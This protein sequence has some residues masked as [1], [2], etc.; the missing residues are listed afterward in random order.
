MH[1]LS[2]SDDG[3]VAYMAH[4]G[5]GFFML[6]SSQIAN[7][8]SPYPAGSPT[9][10]LPAITPLM[11]RVDISPPYYPAVHSALK[12]PGRSV[13]IF[14][15]E[16]YPVDYGMEGCPWGWGW[17]VD[18]SNPAMPH[19]FQTTDPNT[20]AVTTYGQMRLPFN[21]Q[22][23]CPSADQ[24]HQVTYSSHNPTATQNLLIATWYGAGVQIFDTSDPA[25][26]VQVGAYYPDPMPATVD[27]E[28]PG[29]DG[30]KTL[31]WSY[32]IIRNGLIY[33]VDIRNG[34]YILKYTGPHANEISAISFSEG[35]SN[36]K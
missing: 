13:A 7:A 21:E 24:Q 20:G 5:G 31:M 12:V 1:S 17:L 25:H 33:V 16:V 30:T 14:T 34:L 28:D 3:K 11:S 18:I 26:P 6:D 35:N 15:N 23:R 36:L 27:T 2:I 22:D 32:P 4:L 8:A 9:L 19:L 29:I 10:T